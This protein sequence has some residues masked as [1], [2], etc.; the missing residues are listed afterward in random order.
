MEESVGAMKDKKR[1]LKVGVI[2]GGCSPEHEISLQSAYNVLHALDKEKYEVI[3]LG[4]DKKGRWML[5][6]SENPILDIEKA[7]TIHLNLQENNSLEISPG[8]N[9][10]LLSSKE[11]LRSP[12]KLDV[13][14]P[15]IHGPTGEDGSL[16]GLLQFIDIPHVGPGVLSS[17]ACMDK[18][19][20]KQILK[21]VHLPTP[22][23]LSFE[24]TE[25]EKIDYESVIKTLK[26][27]I[28]I[29]PANMG[30]SVGI[31]KVKS[32][33]E[34]LPAI[35]DAF[36]YDHKI[37]IEESIEG[38]E[39]EFAVLGNDDLEVSVPG[40][41][42]PDEEFYSYTSKYCESKTELIAP[43]KLPEKTVKEM[44]KIAKQAF[45]ALNCKG[46]ARVDFLLRGEEI[47][48]NEINTIPG[49]TDISC[50]PLLWKI[51]GIP[52]SELIDKL[53]DLALEAHKK[54]KGLKRS[55]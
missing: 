47:F 45:K 54:N 50:Y 33:A 49:F 10:E 26:S 37:I 22:E 17:A 35:T 42:V 11:P 18:V 21:Q 28:F 13:I 16:Q 9:T 38:R 12:G 20:T 31:H 41:I 3:P 40:E 39:I 43:A 6:N 30:S 55:Y 15:L 29:K 32:K 46:M 44:Q 52:Y 2:F 5:L 14:F 53:I 27:P 51:S 23:F 7:K 25:K 36:L 48:I 1:K 8:E 24:S 4:I 19:F 34:F